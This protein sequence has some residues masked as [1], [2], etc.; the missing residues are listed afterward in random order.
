MQIHGSK[1]TVLRVFLRFWSLSGSELGGVGSVAGV[2]CM[3]GLQRLIEVVVVLLVDNYIG[4]RKAYKYGNKLALFPFPKGLR[5]LLPY[6]VF[7]L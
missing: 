6:R 5:Y 2:G 1:P 4:Y 7:R 3:G